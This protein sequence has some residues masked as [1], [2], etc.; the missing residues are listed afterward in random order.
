MPLQMARQQVRDEFETSAAKMVVTEF[1]LKQVQQILGP[2][3][4]Q[5]QNFYQAEASEKIKAAVGIHCLNPRKT[6]WTKVDK[7]PRTRV[8]ATGDSLG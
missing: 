2:L 4:S 1:Y 3:H 7:G 6:T 5:C 8:A